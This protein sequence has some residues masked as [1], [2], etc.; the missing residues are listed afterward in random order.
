MENL[1]TMEMRSPSLRSFLCLLCVDLA[2][3]VSTVY[4]LSNYNHQ[5]LSSTCLRWSPASAV[6]ENVV[7][8]GEMA[9][10][11]ARDG[12]KLLPGRTDGKQ[13]CVV[14]ERGRTRRERRSGVPSQILP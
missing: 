6:K 14:E 8:V 10:C 12:V 3:S 2:M 13:G 7:K 11:R 4:I 1:K 5:L 9:V